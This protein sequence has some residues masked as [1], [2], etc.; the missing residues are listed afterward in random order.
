MK[1][2]KLLLTHSLHSSLLKKIQ[3]TFSE[4]EIIQALKQDD[5][6]KHLIDSE[7]ILGWRS[8]FDLKTIMDNDQ[9][10]WIQT[11]SAGVNSLPLEQLRKRISLLQVQMAYMA[12][13]FQKQ[14]L[15][16]YLV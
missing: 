8:S 15:R 2:R 10:K 14:F 6:Q 3:S 16:S 5:W 4:W 11:W 12:T 7:I 9:L 13:L 1:K